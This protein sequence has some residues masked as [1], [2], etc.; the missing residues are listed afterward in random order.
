MLGFADVRVEFVA[1]P[2]SDASEEEM[3]RKAE[4]ALPAVMQALTTAEPSA[5]Q[6]V[7]DVAASSSCDS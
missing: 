6:D 3:E 7:Q 1:H 2:I 4:G 5:L